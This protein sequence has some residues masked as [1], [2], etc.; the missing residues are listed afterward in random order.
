MRTSCGASYSSLAAVAGPSQGRPAT[1]C[2]GEALAV[3]RV[4]FAF[5]AIRSTAWLAGS[6]EA[7]RQPRFPGRGGTPHG[8][9]PEDRGFASAGL[10]AKPGRAREEKPR[11]QDHNQPPPRP[12]PSRKPGG[13]P[14]RRSRRPWTAAT[15]AVTAPPPLIATAN[16]A[17]APRPGPHRAGAPASYDPE[18]RTA[19]YECQPERGA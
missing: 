9:D 16:P 2:G 14:R 10:P 7:Q 13:G 8:D 3:F 5:S 4:A 11:C 17:R 18:R 1:R 15:T 6:G 19:S 12:R